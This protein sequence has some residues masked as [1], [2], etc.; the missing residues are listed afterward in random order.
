MCVCVWG[1]GG[2]GVCACISV[3]CAAKKMCLF[4]PLEFCFSVI[5]KLKG[6]AVRKNLTS[7][8]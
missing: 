3:L 7:N 5:K 1:G 2:G 8:K 6:I 4:S